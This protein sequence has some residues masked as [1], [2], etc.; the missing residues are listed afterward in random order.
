[1]SRN[2]FLAGFA[3]TVGALA[4]MPVSTL[5]NNSPGSGGSNASVIAAES[6]AH[7]SAIFNS[8][9]TAPSTAISS[10]LSVGSYGNFE[11]AYGSG[12]GPTSDVTGPMFPKDDGDTDGE[13]DPSE[14][15][16]SPSHSGS[17]FS[18]LNPGFA[19]GL[20]AMDLYTQSSSGG[21]AGALQ[22]SGGSSFSA[23]GN[24][25]SGSGS[26]GSQFGGGSGFGGNQLSPVDT[27]E[28][29]GLA[30]FAGAGIASV[31]VLKRKRKTV[32]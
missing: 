11:D 17:P 16:G 18:F 12:S 14:P 25:S 20:L 1:M 24:G 30:L 27:P 8:A 3:V 5:A 13:F 32:R 2:G 22:S 28:P 6:A 19:M 31:T 4:A 26:G 10:A 23:G 7:G 15:A 9:T 21:G 29:G